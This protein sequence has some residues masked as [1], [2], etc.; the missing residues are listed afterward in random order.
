MGFELYSNLSH[1][2]LRIDWANTD[3]YSLESL[4]SSEVKLKTLLHLWELHHISVG[5]YD[6]FQETSKTARSKWLDCRWA[7]NRLMTTLN[8]P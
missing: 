6:N 1:I 7:L 4:T 5:K 3:K 8:F 2:S